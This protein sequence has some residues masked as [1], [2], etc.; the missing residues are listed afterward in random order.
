MTFL[1]PVNYCIYRLPYLP[2][3]YTQ[4]GLLFLSTKA[5]TI[6]TN[7]THHLRPNDLPILSTGLTVSVISSLALATTSGDP[8]ISIFV[9]PL[10]FSSLVTFQY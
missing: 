2:Q 7:G 9:S 1:N 8:V 3:S 10:S 5:M 4:S 6:Q